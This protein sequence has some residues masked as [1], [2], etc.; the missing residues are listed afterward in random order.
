MT[1]STGTPPTA[2][3][4]DT[5]LV[6]V[7]VRVRA[8]ARAGVT[9]RVRV[10]VRVRVSPIE[11]HEIG[12][13]CTKFCVPSIGS[14]YHV[15]GSAAVIVGTPAPAAAASSPTTRCSGK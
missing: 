2:S 6:R 10:R 12:S 8:R 13:E 7:R 15:G 1:P 5:H 9:F 4:I 3:P 14:T 11:T